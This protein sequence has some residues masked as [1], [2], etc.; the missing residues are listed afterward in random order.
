MSKLF[1]RCNSAVNTFIIVKNIFLTVKKI[2]FIYQYYEYSQR[3]A[4]NGVN[5]YGS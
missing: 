1:S 5:W 4:S 2:I 3:F